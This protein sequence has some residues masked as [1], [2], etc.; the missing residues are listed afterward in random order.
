MD[1]AEKTESPWHRD[2]TRETVPCLIV[3]EGGPCGKE[4][5]CCGRLPV[6]SVCRR[7]GQRNRLGFPPKPTR[8]KKPFREREKKKPRNKKKEGKNRD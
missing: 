4:L 3:V 8:E 5:C 2:I 1:L 6:T 7:D